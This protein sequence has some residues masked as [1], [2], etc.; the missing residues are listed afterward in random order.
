M[1]GPRASRERLRALLGWLFAVACLVWIFH[2]LKPAEL[3]RS[4]HGL[5]WWWVAPAVAADILSYFCQGARW[6]LLLRP[7]GRV[8]P[9]RATRAIYAGLFTNEL[10]PL[11]AGEVVRSYLVS[12]WTGASI[13]RVVPSIA[14]ERLFDGFWLSIA[15]ALAALSVRLP[16]ELA[17]AADVMGALVLAGAVLLAIVTLRRPRAE[18]AAPPA[19][20]GLTGRLRRLAGR[21]LHELR[22]MARAPGFP[23]AALVSVGVLVGQALAFWLVMVAC[24]LPLSI[25]AGAITLMIVHLGTALPNAPGNLGSYQFFCV[26]GLALFGIGKAEAAAF[27]LVV[28]VLLTVPLWALGF[29]ALRGSGLSLG[30]VRREAGDW[31]RPGNNA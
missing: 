18:A 24:G 2:D 29:F 25:W 28:F 13:A 22:A 1:N 10:L 23:A 17:R 7:L 5:R 15:F 16:R 27:S 9:L 21:F 14:V 6:S 11:R 26:V 31:L 12:R 19:G 3:R 4:L 20:R 30:R 8:S